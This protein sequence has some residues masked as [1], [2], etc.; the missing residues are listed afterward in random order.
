[1][2]VALEAQGLGKLLDFGLTSLVVAR[3]RPA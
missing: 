2:D 1:M 3:R